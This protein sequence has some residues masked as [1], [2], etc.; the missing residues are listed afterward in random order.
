MNN[1]LELGYSCEIAL[2]RLLGLYASSDSFKRDWE[3]INTRVELTELYRL[4][5]FINRESLI[6]MAFKNRD[7]FTRLTDEWR[8]DWEELVKVI[9]DD[10]RMDVERLAGKWGLRCDWGC[11]FIMFSP[12]FGYGWEFILSPEPPNSTADLTVEISVYDNNDS[13]KQKLKD[14]KKRAKEFPETTQKNLGALDYR[15]FEKHAKKDIATQ[16]QWL[17]WHITPPYLNAVEIT[18][19]SQNT[20]EV[21]CS[22]EYYIQRCYISMA[23]LLGISLSKGWTKG[24]ARAKQD[25]RGRLRRDVIE[26]KMWL[27]NDP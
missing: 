2:E 6:D 11:G 21:Y 4:E 19:R 13:I 7:N 8:H 26:A 3:T 25:T 22:N 23:K 9:A 20:D 15:G 16:V 14:Q 18:M 12:P 1:E 27:K 17:F 24:R 5:Q 10:A